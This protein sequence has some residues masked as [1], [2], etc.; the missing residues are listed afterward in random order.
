MRCGNDGE[1]LKEQLELAR[2][3]CEML[4]SGRTDEV[5][6]KLRKNPIDISHIGHFDE[7][8]NTRNIMAKKITEKLTEKEEDAVQVD[9]VNEYLQ[10]ESPKYGLGQ[11]LFYMENNKVASFTVF[12]RIVEEILNESDDG[13]QTVETTIYYGGDN[14]RKTYLEDI[15]YPSKE[16]LLNSL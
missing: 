7:Q 9:N 6:E 1:Y 11:R 2:L 8:K 13:Q 10:G 12:H 15:L 5:L 16:A 4:E 3:M 14:L